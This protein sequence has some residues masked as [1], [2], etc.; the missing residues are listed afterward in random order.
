[1]ID[2]LPLHPSHSQNVSEHCRKTTLNRMSSLKL[3]EQVHKIIEKISTDYTSLT[4][5]CK[6]DLS[7]LAN[8]S[9]VDKSTLIVKENQNADKLYFVVKGCFRVYYLKDG[10]DVT[11]W[12]AFENDFVSSINSF[13]QF[14]PSLHYIE[15]LEPTTYLEIKREDV[16]RLTEKHHCFETLSRK[17]IT[18]IMLGLQTRIVALQFET[19]RQKYDNLIKIRPDIVQRVPLMHIAT[20]LG[21]TLETISRV[22]N[23]K[24]RI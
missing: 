13:F 12:F 16:F 2:S 5:E 17:A 9:S 20:H 14:I 11:D 6:K 23:Q 1:M 21:L 7:R 24:N 22:R 19:A 18:Q 8:I 15:A 10:K 4:H 3:N